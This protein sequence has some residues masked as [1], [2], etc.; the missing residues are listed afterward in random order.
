MRSELYQ[1]R[2]SYPG[3]GKHAHFYYSLRRK[4]SLHAEGANSQE[5]P[6]YPR[7]FGYRALWLLYCYLYCKVLRN[8][9]VFYLV[10]A[11]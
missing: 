5:I 7:V 8:A 1:G 10:C 6:G 3:S 2:N 11:T 4:F 9:L